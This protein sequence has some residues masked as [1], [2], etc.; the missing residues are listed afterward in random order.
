MVTDTVIHETGAFD[1]EGDSLSFELIE[2]GGLFCD[3]INGYQFPSAFGGF[4]TLDSLGVLSFSAAIQCKMQFAIKVTKWRMGVELCSAY[5][6]ILLENYNVGVNEINSI[7]QL[8]V[9]PNPAMQ[10]IILQLDSEKNFE[11]EIKIYDITGNLIFSQAYY[12]IEGENEINVNI[13]NFSSGIYWVRLGNEGKG[14][15]FC[16]N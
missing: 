5:R 16:K 9:F 10:N 12:I 7:S 14:V 6:D 1:P 13:A 4:E 3:E 11:E 2:C 8:N 15:K